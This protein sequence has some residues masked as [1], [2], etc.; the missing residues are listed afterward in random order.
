MATIAFITSTK[1]HIMA[2]AIKFHMRCISEYWVMELLKMTP[3][4]PTGVIN[5][6]CWNWRF[7][8]SYYLTLSS[9]KRMTYNGWLNAI[10]IS[11]HISPEFVFDLWGIILCTKVFGC[12]NRIKFYG[13]F[14][15]QAYIYHCL[16]KRFLCLKMNWYV[17]NFSGYVQ[18]FSNPFVY[19][20]I[21]NRATR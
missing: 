5:T 19:L 15:H 8:V 12:K 7:S 17:E 6:L 21:W 20:L 1:Q 11:I 9:T 13:F 3:V 18:Q 2:T 14:Q 16:W 10:V 4:W